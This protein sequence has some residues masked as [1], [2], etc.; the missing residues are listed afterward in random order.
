MDGAINLQ[1][2]ASMKAGMQP[3]V[4]VAPAVPVAPEAP[5]VPAA[6]EAPEVP[7]PDP[8]APPIDATPAPA[9]DPASDPAAAGPDTEP[10]ETDAAAD[11]LMDA[12][13]AAADPAAA[14][15]LVKSFLAAHQSAASAAALSG[16][17]E[18]AKNIEAAA[19]EYQDAANGMFEAHPHLKDYGGL[20]ELVTKDEYGKAPG[21]KPS[22]LYASVAK[23]ANGMLQLQKGGPSLPESA[24]GFTPPVT[25]APKNETLNDKRLRE[26]R[27][28]RGGK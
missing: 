8:G 16:L 19:K 7:A 24:K 3:Q 10:G 20:M 17:P 22:D 2:L 23:R 15:A 11:A 6:P 18:A 26:M 5:A 9:G 12:V 27:E 25:P 14:R 21:A 28:G 13:E 4:P 1:R